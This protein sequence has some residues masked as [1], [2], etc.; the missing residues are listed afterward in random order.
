MGRNAPKPLAGLPT[1]VVNDKGRHQSLGSR[2]LAADPLLARSR[3]VKAIEFQNH[4]IV[5]QGV[6][7][8]CEFKNQLLSGP[9]FK[10]VLEC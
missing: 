9:D 6:K 7:L 3:L 1:Q 10:S 5:E 2:I 8:T 4:V